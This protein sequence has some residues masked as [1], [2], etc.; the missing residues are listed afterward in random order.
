MPT[1]TTASQT[2]SEVLL[3][4]GIWQEKEMEDIRIGKEETTIVIHG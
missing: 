4:D 2:V 1:A 3:V